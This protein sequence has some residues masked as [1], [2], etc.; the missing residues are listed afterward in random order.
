MVIEMA[1]LQRLGRFCIDPS[2]FF[3]KKS[4]FRATAT[5]KH[6]TSRSRNYPVVCECKSAGCALVV[7]IASEELSEQVGAMR[8]AIL[9]GTRRRVYKGV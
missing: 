7:S 1:E 4:L 5:S 8:R 6:T 9:P 2:L 3:F